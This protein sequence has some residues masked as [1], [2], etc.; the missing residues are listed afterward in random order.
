MSKSN[1]AIVTNNTIIIT[2]DLAI[3]KYSKVPLK[4][5]PQL[6][7][8]N[9]HKLVTQANGTIY[10]VNG[11]KSGHIY[12]SGLFTKLLKDNQNIVYIAST[13]S[14]ST[15]YE[16]AIIARADLDQK[17]RI[18]VIN[19]KT[20]SAGVLIIKS[21]LQQLLSE[22]LNI[23]EAIS[24]LETYINKIDSNFYIKN[25]ERTFF[26]KKT[27]SIKQNL[28]FNNKL[29]L[30]TDVKDLVNDVINYEKTNSIHQ[31]Y[32]TYSSKYLSKEV[33][34]IKTYLEHKIRYNNQIQVIEDS[35]DLIGFDTMQGIGLYI[36]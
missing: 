22:E 35:K 24:K 4:S 31:I 32:L 18:F 25:T 7:T 36:G 17:N 33:N 12:F 9:L 11:G 21:Y 26:I 29:S 15:G 6:L 34:V 30:N 10:S 1:K 20:I 28:N 3:N 8:T 19:S 27:I 14:L 5:N 16:D 2:D 13:S 23:Q